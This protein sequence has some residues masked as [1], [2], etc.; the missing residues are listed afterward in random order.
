M[1]RV[2]VVRVA[3]VRVAVVDKVAVAAMG[4]VGL[5]TPRTPT[6]PETIPVRTNPVRKSRTGTGRWAMPNISGS[7]RNSTS[8][9]NTDSS[10]FITWSAAPYKINAA[11]SKWRIFGNGVAATCRAIGSSINIARVGV[12]RCTKCSSTAASR[13]SSTVTI[14]CS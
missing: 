7:R 3:V 10:S 13:S 9:Q 4:C 5:K 2:A 11:A 14:T 6:P 12:N 8:P 1:V